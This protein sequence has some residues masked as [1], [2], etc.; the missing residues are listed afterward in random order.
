[1]KL[2]RW[3]AAISALAGIAVILFVQRLTTKGPTNF[4]PWQFGLLVLPWPV[5]FAAFL[6]LVW[7]SWFR[8]PWFGRPLAG[9]VWL[10]LQVFY[11]LFVLAVVF[12][13]ARIYLFLFR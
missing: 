3:I 6:P 11:S 9:P 2:L 7:E 10:L 8:R 5:F 12:T 4:E 13:F 1:M